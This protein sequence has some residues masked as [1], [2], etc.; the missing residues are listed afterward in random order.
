MNT[1]YSHSNAKPAEIV[2]IQFSILSK[3]DIIKNS[4]VSVH[5]IEL[6]DKNVPNENG[7]YDLRMGTTTRTYNCLTC[8]CDNVNCPG[9]FGHIELVYPVYN[10]SY[11][12]TIYK[13]IQCVCMKC[14]SFLGVYE[15]FPKIPKNVSSSRRILRMKRVLDSMKKEQTCEFCKFVQPKWS[16]ENFTISCC[17]N[18]EK[19]E[20]VAVDI[21]IILNILRKIDDCVCDVIGLNSEYSH[22]KNMIYEALPVPPPVIRPSVMMNSSYRTQ[23][24]LTYKL[25]D[26]IKS[27]QVLG[28]SIKTNEDAL[29][30][31]EHHNNLQ[32]HINTFIDNEIP[33]QPQATQ[34]TGRPI[35]SLGQR[36]RSKEGRVRG[37]LMGKRVDFSARSVI[38]AEPNIMLDELGVPVDISRNMT[39]S[40][41][42]NIYNKKVLQEYVNVGSNPIKLKQIGAKYVIT[43]DGV[44]KDLRYAKNVKIDV[45]DVVE[46]HLKD[47]DYVVFNRQPTLHKMSMMGHKVV[48]MPHNTFRMNLSATS[49][50]NADLTFTVE[51]GTGSCSK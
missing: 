21:K 42:V 34:R 24:D 36:I 32:F 12:K 19:T 38:T 23:D 13:I 37:N 25:T 18:S 4:V 10:L 40:E 48:V 11:Y 3:E 7:L 2:G 31:Q 6:Y 27:N 50:Y 46:R 8:G 43:K 47:G 29:V 20:T 5:N 22:P 15:K 1:R 16:L 35:K 9:H 33:G 17:F 26:I 51:V 49:S 45:G 44:R 14:S 41:N 30:I 28:K 39:F